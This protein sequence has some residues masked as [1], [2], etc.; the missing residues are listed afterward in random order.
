MLTFIIILLAIWAVV[1]VLGFA[2]KGLIWLAF[3]GIIL[4]IATAIIG[5]IRG[6]ASRT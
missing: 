1:A 2:I 6:R 5:W 4:F 3:I